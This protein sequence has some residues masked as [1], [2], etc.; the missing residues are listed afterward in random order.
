MICVCIGSKHPGANRRRRLDNYMVVG[1]YGL[2]VRKRSL[3]DAD[4]GWV[5][6]LT[7]PHAPTHTAQYA[8]SR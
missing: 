6:I 8:E 7:F 5:N 2:L 4:N 3:K 1:K